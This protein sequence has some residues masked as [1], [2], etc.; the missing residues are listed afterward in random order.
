MERT[1]LCMKWGDLYGPDYVNVLYRAVRA[2]LQGDFRF[3]CLTDDSDGFIDEIETFPIPDM[4]LT[5]FDWKKGGWPKLSVFKKDLYDLK[6]RC[7]FLDLDSVICGPLEPLFETSGDV[8]GIDT[9]QNWKSLS[10]GNAPLTGTGV[11]TF[12]F[13]AYPDIFDRFVANREKMVATYRIEQIYLENELPEGTMK[14]WPIEWVQ[15]FKYHL[16]RPPL[17]GLLMRPRP[18]PQ[19]AHVVAFH[20]EPRPIDLVRSGIWGLGPNWGLGRVP[21]AVEYWARHEGDPDKS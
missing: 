10:D 18:L 8:V 6:G 19:R 17:L 1:V 3:V 14:H 4:G 5:E 21:W 9:G 11:F 7:L 20:G 15:S 16:Q 12:T 2:H 13:N